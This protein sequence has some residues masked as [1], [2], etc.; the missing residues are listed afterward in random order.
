MIIHGDIA[1]MII[2][3]VLVLIMIPGLALFYG[4]LVEKKKFFN[5]SVLML[6]LNRY[7]YSFIDIWWIWHGIR[8]WYQWCYS[9]CIFGWF[10]FNAGGSLAAADTSTIVFTNTSVA[11]VFGMITWSIFHY[12]EHK[13]FSFLEMI[14]VQ[15][16]VL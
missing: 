14:L 8:K 3:T 11:G 15:L 1:F 5:Y 4:G 9:L 13:R 16:L 6:Y 2:S 7:C 12:I 10:G